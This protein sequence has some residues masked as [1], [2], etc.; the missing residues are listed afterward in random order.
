MKV[1]LINPS[2]PKIWVTPRVVPLGLAYIAAVLEHEGHRVKVL[3]LNVEKLDQEDLLALLVKEAPDVVGV[4]ATTPLIKQAWKICKMVKESCE[5]TTVVG[6][7]HASALPDESLEKPYVD[8]VVR[9]EGEGTIIEVCAKIEKDLSLGEVRGISCKEDEKIV[10]NPPR[11]LRDLDSLPFPAYHL[12]KYPRLYGSPQPLISNRVPAANILTSRGCPWN[13]MFCAKIA[14]PRFWRA[15]SSEKVVEE[16]RWL[17]DK[18]RVREMGIVDDCFTLDKRRVLKICELLIKEG[19]DMPWCT[20]N[21]VRADTLDRELLSAMKRAGCYHIDIGAESGN[22]DVLNRIGKGETLDQIKEAVTIAKDVGL[23]VTVYFMIG[24]IGE[25]KK[26]M[27]DTI[28]F[29]KKLNPDYVQ[30]TVATPYP[31]SK[32]YEIVRKEEKLLIDNWELYGHYEGRAF[33]EYGDVNKELVEEMYKR[34]YREF[35]MRP[36]YAFKLL[37]KKGTW[38]NM[39]NIAKGFLHFMLDRYGD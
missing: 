21:G 35:Y 28:K 20:P 25:N 8:I 3:D 16:W 29:A 24:N 11:E 34:A 6:G 22:Q 10:H 23:E 7:P 15:R 4:T 33:F 13:C 17:V 12:F 27:L 26:T 32:L 37:M 14:S 9:E 38:R 39:S 30:F 1:V 5:A 2:P 36:K 19:L 18:F 31:G